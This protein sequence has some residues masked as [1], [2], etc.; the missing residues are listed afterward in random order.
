[1]R[2]EGHGSGGGYHVSGTLA[3]PGSVTF[4]DWSHGMEGSRKESPWGG[5][6]EGAFSSWTGSQLKSCRGGAVKGGWGLR[7]LG[8]KQ[9]NDVSGSQ[10]A[11]EGNWKWVISVYDVTLSHKWVDVGL[12]RD[13]VLLPYGLKA[14]QNL[15]EKWNVRCLNRQTILLPCGWMWPCKA[16]ACKKGWFWM[17]ECVCWELLRGLGRYGVTV[18][19]RWR[20]WCAVSMCISNTKE[21]KAV[22]LP[23][24]VYIVMYIPES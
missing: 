6:T 10:A 16:E 17:W 3:V 4:E 5:A 9:L 19:G 14:T 1:M 21:N 22:A 23:F 24:S 11:S 8:V 18:G 12:D 13:Q 15:R 2:V 7:V 20:E